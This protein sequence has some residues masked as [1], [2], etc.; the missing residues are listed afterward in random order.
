MGKKHFPIDLIVTMVDA[1]VLQTFADQWDAW[2]TIHLYQ[3]LSLYALAC[4]MLMLST[5]FAAKRVY[6]IKE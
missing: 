1:M 6:L 2:N 4:V 3:Q 5:P